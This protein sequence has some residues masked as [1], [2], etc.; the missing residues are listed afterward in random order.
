LLIFFTSF[1]V[2]FSLVSTTWVCTIFDEQITVRTQNEETAEYTLRGVIYYG[3]YHYTCRW[4]AQNKKTWWHDRMTTG[5]QLTDEGPWSPSLNLQVLG[6][7]RAAL[8]I[9]A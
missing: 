7:R 9:Y 1:V 6:S 8:A 3:G 2:S 5:V 4:I